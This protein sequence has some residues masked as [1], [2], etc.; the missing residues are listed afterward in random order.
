M[1]DLSGKRV[2]ITGGARGIGLSLAL[3]FVEEG[4]VILLTDLDEPALEPALE[5]VRMKGGKDAKA[6]AA[7][8]A[9]AAS[10]A[11]LRE[12]V[13]RAAGPVDVL[14]NNA[15]LVFGGP[16]LDV[17]LDRHAKTFAVNL[18]GVVA[19]THA[20]LPDLLARPEGHLVN[21]ASASGMLGLPNGATYA[22]SKWGVIGFSDSLRQELEL[23]GHGHVRVTTV[24][25]SY[26][27][28]GLFDGAR[29]P[30][31]VPFLKPEKVAD[32]TVRAVR[33]DKLYVRA[34]LM[35]KTIPLLKGI[36]PTR[37]F[38]VTSR[39]LRVSTSM[40]EWRGH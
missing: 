35:V 20:F 34:P 23:Q 1:R 19:M 24:C 14:V 10:V 33:H 36:L 5:A 15:G 28:T 13:H 2:L 21:V 22:A 16:F 8:V 11:A 38:E 18:G 9:D 25:P 32:L 31:L 17:P 27:T 12:R 30:S 7:D 4:A 37:L 29:A 26:V 40:L 3:R 6:F 39:V